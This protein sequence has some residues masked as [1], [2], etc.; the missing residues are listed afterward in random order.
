MVSLTAEALEKTLP[1]DDTFNRKY[2]LKYGLDFLTLS[3][4]QIVKAVK[5]EV[6]TQNSAD[7]DK[8][9]R[10]HMKMHELFN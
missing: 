9:I 5:L 2:L 1:Q 3:F 10:K 6:G 8:F 7:A 4:N